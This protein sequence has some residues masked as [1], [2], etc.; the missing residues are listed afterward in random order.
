MAFACGWRAA[1]NTSLRRTFL[2]T[3]SKENFLFRHRILILL[4]VE[5]IT[6]KLTVQSQKV[7]FKL[8]PGEEPKIHTRLAT[9]Y[10]GES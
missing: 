8:T 10:S 2:M 9:F 3:I 4:C 5:Q 7:C 6:A 1:P